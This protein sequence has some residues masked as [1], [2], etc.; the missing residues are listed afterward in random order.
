MMPRDTERDEQAPGLAENRAHPRVKVH[1]LAYIELGQENAGLILNI[2]ESGM[3]IQAV[4]TLSSNYLPRMHFRLPHTDALIQTSGKVVWQIKSKKEL[5]IEF[6]AISDQTRD[7]IRKWIATEDNR[8]S[9]SEETHQRALADFTKPVPQGT[10]FQKYPSE[11]GDDDM[12]IPVPMTAPELATIDPPVAQPEFENRASTVADSPTVADTPIAA[13]LPAPL[14]FPSA[15]KRLPDR[16]RA[17]P[18]LPERHAPIP[19]PIPTPQ[20]ER[21]FGN[22]AWNRHAQVP[23][24]SI[25]S[26]GK[27]P[28]WPYALVVILLAAVV[29][30][31]VSTVDPGLIDAASIE[32]W[33][34]NAAASFKLK[35]P[36]QTAATQTQQA[37]ATSPT[38]NTALPPATAQVPPVAQS[39]SPSATQ[40][41]TQNSTPNVPSTSPNAGATQ[42]Q[43]PGDNDASASTQ[44]TPPIAD[45]GRSDTSES[46]SAATTSTPNQAGGAIQ[47]PPQHQS[48]P[49]QSRR[50][51]AE[52][53]P[54]AS[55]YGHD[56]PT[57][58]IQNGAPS[59]NSQFAGSQRSA[60][61]NNRASYGARTS[62]QAG[63]QNQTAP[64][65]SPSDS[66]APQAS[67]AQTV[68][69]ASSNSAPNSTS[70]AQNQTPAGQN[71]QYQNAYANSAP[72]VAASANK[73][74]Q[75]ATTQPQAFIVEMSGYPN[76]PVPPS[77]PLAGVPSGSVAANSQLH[78]IWVPTNLEWARQYLPANLGVGRLLSSYS[79]AYPI[80][81]AREGVQGTVKLDV[82]IAMD[83]TVRSVRILAG[84]PILAHA[85]VS[86]VRDWRYGESFLAGQPVQTQQYVS[87][88]F[89][90]APAR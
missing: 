32:A 77:M 71:N 39:Q 58:S 24:S 41:A 55:S 2:S 80:E 7:V 25:E 63:S 89:R 70:R 78:A 49:A 36:P 42:S 60:L 29:L 5:G 6:D 53:T 13:E 23:R 37:N 34:A 45:S 79:P 11:S 82:T 59:T 17:E 30:A 12:E 83:G 46:N 8:Q 10:A 69:P 44:S 87:I 22:A 57:R 1:S 84:P 28:R 15:S 48:Q 64:R 51:Q 27:R 21:T 33:V 3:A 18:K 67:R 54:P 76:S 61:A 52:Q 75:S 90:L 72:S 16:W 68:P 88:V 20:P 85:A 9:E 65:Q 31:G 73:T 50:T 81:A 35:H 14:E 40:N 4:Q 74:P 19:R 66:Q 26:A 47:A 62:S 86:A 43:R 56:A 38:A